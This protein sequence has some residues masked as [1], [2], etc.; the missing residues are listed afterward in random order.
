[1]H[2]PSIESGGSAG[3]HKAYRCATASENLGSQRPPTAQSCHPA[4]AFGHESPASSGRL[5]AQGA[6][7]RTET[8]SLTKF[9]S[10]AR[11]VNRFPPQTLRSFLASFT[12]GGV[13]TILGGCIRSHAPPKPCFCCSQRGSACSIHKSRY[14]VKHPVVLTALG[15]RF[16]VCRMRFDG[17]AWHALSGDD[18]A[19][20]EHFFGHIAR[21]NEPPALFAMPA[22]AG[23]NQTFSHL[24]PR[25]LRG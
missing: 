20:T 6:I 7:S 10:C 18:E 9:S 22:L 13:R 24:G 16:V 4:I 1:M 12:V 2:A 19:R 8:Q 11:A 5:I 25:T 21:L 14:A 3:H 23:H 15:R 17:R